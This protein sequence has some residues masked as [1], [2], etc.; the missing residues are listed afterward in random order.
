MILIFDKKEWD[1]QLDEDMKRLQQ[2][3]DRWDVIHRVAEK[4]KKKAALL[5]ARTN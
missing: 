2:A 3:L 5:N 4:Q 1:T